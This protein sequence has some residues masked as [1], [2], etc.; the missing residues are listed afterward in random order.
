MRHLG[1]RSFL[2]TPPAGIGEPL[3][4]PG[5]TAADCGPNTQVLHRDGK[6]G[7]KQRPGK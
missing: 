7:P 1:V 5:E 3:R 4:K 2:D 6:A